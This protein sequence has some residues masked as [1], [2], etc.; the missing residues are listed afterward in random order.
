MPIRIL[1]VDDGVE[2]LGAAI[3]LL[4]TD[5]QVKVVGQALSGAA[6]LEQI[7]TLKPELVLMDIALP[8]CNSLEDTRMIKAQANAP[9]VVIL[10][11]NDHL[12]YRSAAAAVR[13]DGFVAKP[14]CG[15]KRLPLI[16]M[17]FGVDVACCAAARDRN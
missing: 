15:E 8:G 7:T 13:A 1:L 11:L 10:T 12:E 9:R 6:A 16:R 3:R 4:S 17:L 14:D 5:A 2:F